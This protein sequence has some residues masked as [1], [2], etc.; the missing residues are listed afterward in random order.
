MWLYTCDSLDFG[1]GFPKFGT[2]L[3]EFLRDETG[4]GRGVHRFW[5]F[6][7]QKPRSNISPFSDFSHFSGIFGVGVVYL[8]VA[9]PGA[10]KLASL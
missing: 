10:A 3:G 4:S 1:R 7:I 9:G 6:L 2:I 5:H 8:G